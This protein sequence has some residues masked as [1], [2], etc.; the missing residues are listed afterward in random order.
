MKDPNHVIVLQHAACEAPGLIAQSLE[1]TGY[2]LKPVHTFAGDSI[3]EEMGNAAGLVVMGGPMGVYDQERYPFLPSEMRLIE[4]ALRQEKPLLG[5]CLGSQLLASALGSAVKQ[6]KRKE[7]GWHPVTLS[8]AGLQDPLLSGV[9]RS[10][11]AFHWHGDTFDLPA[12]S[13]S[14]ASSDLTSYQAFRSGKKAY[15]FLFHMEITLDILRGMSS[16]FTDELKEEGL[17]GAEIVNKAR[18]H[19][20]VLGAVGSQVFRRWAALLEDR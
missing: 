1:E 8:E 2:S 17:D 3:P 15:G 5:V 20:P 9:E 6:G 16:A 10:F 19:L 11:M 13:T 12:S 14:L 4:N 18:N 7:I